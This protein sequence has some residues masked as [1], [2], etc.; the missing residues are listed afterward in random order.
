MVSSSHQIGGWNWFLKVHI[1]FWFLNCFEGLEAELREKP[2]EWHD[3]KTQVGDWNW[4]IFS[5]NQAQH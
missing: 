5:E 4:Y 3:A 1:H 2:V